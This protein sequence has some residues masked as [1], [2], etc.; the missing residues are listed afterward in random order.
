[1]NH[2]KQCCL[3]GLCFLLADVFCPVTSTGAQ[4]KNDIQKLNNTLIFDLFLNCE[5]SV[6]YGN[7][8]TM[9]DY[10][11]DRSSEIFKSMK[12]ESNIGGR[13]NICNF[14][15]N[16]NGSLNTLSYEIRDMIYTYDF[17]Y[18]SDRLASVSIGGIKKI[19]CT[20][21]KK[22]ILQTITRVSDGRSLE[23]NFYYHDGENKA[24]IK[25][26]IVQDGNKIPNP[27]EGFVSWND[28]FKISDYRLDD[29][30]AKELKYSAEGNL[31]QKMELVKKI[32]LE[33]D[34]CK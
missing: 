34:S 6:R 29:F 20:Y 4:K 16:K 33:F 13:N 14:G 21:N 27:E 22:G 10:M 3:I 30:S 8:A 31:E 12:V 24:R 18:E 2:F 17:V 25:S 32:A 15:F 19:I 7:L 5:I 23:F 9:A 26:F 11:P 28:Q 1:M